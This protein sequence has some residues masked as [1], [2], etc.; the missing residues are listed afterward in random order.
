[1]YFC[2]QNG[3]TNKDVQA[4]L[5]RARFQQED[6]AIFA[7]NKNHNADVTMTLDMGHV[8]HTRTAVLVQPDD[9]HAPQKMAPAP[10]YS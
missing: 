5:W 7:S 4:R 8:F 3:S 6:V 2:A 9:A 1:M 10:I